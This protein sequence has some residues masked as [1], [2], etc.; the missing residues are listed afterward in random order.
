MPAVGIKGESGEEREE[1]E[2]VEDA[3]PQIS[4]L[5]YGRQT[6][7]GQVLFGSSRS[8]SELIRFPLIPPPQNR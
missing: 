1:K 6:R 8:E 2:M 7:H 5:D 4:I 3:S